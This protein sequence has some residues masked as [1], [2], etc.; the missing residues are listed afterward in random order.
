MAFVILLK[1]TFKNQNKIN[2]MQYVIK[3]NF[4]ELTKVEH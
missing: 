3:T 2:V 1:E 4:L